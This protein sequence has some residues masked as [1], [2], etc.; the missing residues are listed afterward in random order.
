MT[1]TGQEDHPKHIPEVHNAFDTIKL[2][3]SGS[4]GSVWHIR[5]KKDKREYALKYS[6]ATSL[7][8][9]VRAET[10][11]LKVCNGTCNLPEPFGVFRHKTQ[12]YT[13]INYMEHD[14]LMSVIYDMTHE[15]ILDYAKNVFIALEYLHARNVIHRDVKPGNILYNRNKRKYLLVDF[16]LSTFY[17][18]KEPNILNNRENQ[19]EKMEI[20]EDEEELLIA[21]GR[22]PVF[23]KS[24]TQR[25]NCSGKPMSCKRCE[26]APKFSYCKSGTNGYRAPETMLMCLDQTTKL[27]IWSAGATVL[28]LMC[29]LPSVFR[30]DNEFEGIYQYGTILGSNEMSEAAKSWN[31]N[32]MYDKIYPKKSFYRLQKSLNLQTKGQFREFASTHCKHCQTLIFENANGFCIC[33]EGPVCVDQ[34]SSIYEQI[35]CRVLDFTLHPHPAKRFSASELLSFLENELAELNCK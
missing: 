35:V 33:E 30:Y 10:R 5:N 8:H 21:K 1:I 27:D 13:I 25:C 14:E 4:F 6:T 34:Y 28:S 9:S 20:D 26:S 18:K 7:P 17:E 16:G 2:L 29:R 22:E 23:S 3:G 24:V 31:V 11:V 12:F 32:L 15:D 19:A